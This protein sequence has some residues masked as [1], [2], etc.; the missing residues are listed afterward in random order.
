MAFT[1]QAKNKIKAFYNKMDKEEYIS[2]GED[3]LK[4]ELRKK[5]ISATDF[6]S[7]DNIE[8]PKTFETVWIK[9]HGLWRLDVNEAEKEE[10]TKSSKNKKSKEKKS[11]GGGGFS[12]GGLSPLETFVLKLDI[13]L[14]LSGQDKVFGGEIQFY[15]SELFGV[16]VG[17]TGTLGVGVGC[18]VGVGSTFFLLPPHI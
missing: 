11:S 6:L 18:L 16:G 1:N 17:V 7:N 9:E 13:E 12:F 14:P 5:K 8:N 10:E 4:E 3:L 2:T 15:T